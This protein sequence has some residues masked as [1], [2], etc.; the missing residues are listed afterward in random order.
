[1]LQ[2]SVP[3]LVGVSRSHECDI[4]AKELRDIVNVDF[5]ENNLLGDAE[6]VVR[7]EEHTS[8]LQSP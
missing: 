7:S 8:E 2:Q 5:G 3:F 6:S 1:M 4:H